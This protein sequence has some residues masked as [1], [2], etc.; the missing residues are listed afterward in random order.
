LRFSARVDGKLLR[1]GR[2]GKRAGGTLHAALVAE[3]NRRSAGVARRLRRFFDARWRLHVG[4]RFDARTKRLTATATALA[5]P[6]RDP[7]NAA[8]LRIKIDA[9]PGKVPSGRLKLLGGTGAAAGLKGSG[10]F[11]FRLDG[12]GAAT[13]LGPLSVREGKKRPL[14]RAC[15]G[16]R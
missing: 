9:V 6:P 8:C 3:P 4:S 5:R 1:G 13:A 12:D 15:R 16:L 14:P 2:G 10:S 7:R 11:K